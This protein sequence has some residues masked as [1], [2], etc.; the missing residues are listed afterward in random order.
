M[1]S[2]S[3][4]WIIFLKYFTLI[5]LYLLWFKRK[6]V[7]P[8]HLSG[9]HRLLPLLVAC[10]S[11]VVLSLW[12]E[13]GD[14]VCICFVSLTAKKYS[15]QSVLM[16]KG[17]IAII[18]FSLFSN[19]VYSDWWLFCWIVA[20]CPDIAV[21]LKL[22]GVWEACFCIF[23]SLPHWLCPLSSGLPHYWNSI[24]LIVVVLDPIFQQ[25]K[26][27]LSSPRFLIQSL[28]LFCNF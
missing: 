1:I 2:F 16:V 18:I 26:M 14:W 15:Y 23:S 24:H 3:D 22:L 13:R 10:T 20:Q 25:R 9:G 11:W 17:P 7:S 8:S 21:K 5:S 6:C 4:Y 19:L 12:L 28:D 27:L